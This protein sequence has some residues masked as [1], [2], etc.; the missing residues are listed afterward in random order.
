M[1]STITIDGKTRKI[2]GEH[3]DAGKSQLLV[4]GGNVV[5]EIFYGMP[6]Y[7]MPES[8]ALWHSPPPELVRYGNGHLARWKNP[9]ADKPERISSCYCT[10]ILRPAGPGDSRYK[11]IVPRRSDR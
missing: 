1:R 10:V 5:A 9:T 11:Y 8:F 2:I 6:G 7:L 4:L 3:I